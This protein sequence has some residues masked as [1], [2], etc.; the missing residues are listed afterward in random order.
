M[1]DVFPYELSEL[2]GFTQKTERALG[3]ALSRWGS[4][5]G[6]L[7]EMFVLAV[8]A[9]DQI[10]AFFS[11]NAI[12]SA[13]VQ[14]SVVDAAVRHTYKRQSDVIEVWNRIAKEVNKARSVRAKLA[15]GQIIKRTR[16]DHCNVTFA[17]HYFLSHRVELAAFEQWDWKRLEAIGN[18]F[19]EIQKKI[20]L[21]EFY[22]HWEQ[23]K[24]G[25]FPT[26]E[27]ITLGEFLNKSK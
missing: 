18:Y 21:L 3:R 2:E 26:F 22:L 9:R 25:A 5:E 27:P 4:I 10:A 12:N 8:T 19:F 1:K 23:P 13:E 17:P 11:I 15:H 20:S 24:G 7:C 16:A 14:L 6:A